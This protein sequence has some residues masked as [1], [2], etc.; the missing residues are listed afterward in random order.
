[1]GSTSTHSSMRR[2]SSTSHVESQLAVV[3]HRGI[4]VDPGD[5]QRTER[6]HAV[7]DLAVRRLEQTLQPR[8]RHIFYARDGLCRG[9]K[10]A[11]EDAI[12]KTQ[13]IGMEI[14]Q[15]AIAVLAGAKDVEQRLPDVGPQE[16][17]N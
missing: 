15:S 9:D 10:R 5:L 16:A 4:V 12:A 8:D 6:Q 13:A 7:F 14:A 3:G 11:Q 17:R 2:S 1:M